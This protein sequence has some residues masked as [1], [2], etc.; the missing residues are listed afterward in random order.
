MSYPSVDAIQRTLA[1]K[2][3]HYAADRKK[4]S[5]RALG[6]LI[7]IITYYTLKSWGFRDALAIERALPEFGNPEITHNVEY[8]AVP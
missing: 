8:T 7:E 3:F 4:A 2:V 1:D 5:G 6:T